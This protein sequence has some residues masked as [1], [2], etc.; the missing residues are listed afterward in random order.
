MGNK[1][2]HMDYGNLKSKT[3]METGKD[4]YTKGFGLNGYVDYGNLPSRA[5]AEMGKKIID[6]SSPNGYVNLENLPPGTGS[7][8]S[9]AKTNNKFQGKYITAGTTGRSQWRIN[10]N[11]NE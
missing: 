7:I 11:Q 3:I 9:S 4:A 10:F 8:I 2:N 6:E 5:L 1:N